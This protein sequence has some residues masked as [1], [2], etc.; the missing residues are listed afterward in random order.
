MVTVVLILYFIEEKERMREKKILEST[1][2][3]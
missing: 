3:Y 1:F 2:S